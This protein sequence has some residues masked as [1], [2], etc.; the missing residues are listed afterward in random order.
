MAGRYW[1]LEKNKASEMVK[2]CILF[3]KIFGK[4]TYSIS[5]TVLF[6]LC[7]TIGPDNRITTWKLIGYFRE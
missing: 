6:D 7:S 1:Y 5:T 3:E 4:R 2:A